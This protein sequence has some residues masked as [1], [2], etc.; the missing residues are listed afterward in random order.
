M[1]R[2]SNHKKRLELITSIVS[3]KQI[4]TNAKLLSKARILHKRFG[5][6]TYLVCLQVHTQLDYMVYLATQVQ[7]FLLLEGSTSARIEG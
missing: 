5:P 4:K 2:E 1:L 6:Y 7:A 3:I